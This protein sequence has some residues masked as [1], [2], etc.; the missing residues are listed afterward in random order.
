MTSK[1]ARWCDGLM[2]AGWLAA[3]IAIPLFFNIHSDR[4]FEPDKLTLLRSI[5]VLM[6][7]AWL[8]KFIDLQGWQQWSSLHPR[9]EESIWRKPFVLPV[10]LLVI[11]YLI[12]NI[13]SVTPTVSWAGSYQ[14]LQGTYTTLSY[15]VIFGIMI[16]TMRTRAQV[17]RVVTAVI[18]TS[19]P[20]AFYGLL[21]HFELD[22]LPWGGNTAKRI[23]GHMG[24]AIFIAA[25]LI[26]AV[27]LTISRI[28]DAFTSILG[29]EELSY[30][31]VIRSSIYI[32]VVAIQLIAIYWSGSR[33]PWLGLA[34]AAFA[35]IL[36]VLVTL[37]NASEETGRFRLLEVGK[38]LLMVVVG[39]V[40]A[41][42][43]V[44]VIIT[45]VINSGRLQSLA[46][47]MT[48]FVSFGAAVG[49][50]VVAVF[51]MIAARRGWRWLWFSWLLLAVVVGGWLVAFNF[52]Q[53]LNEQMGDVPVVGD[54]ASALV[55]WQELP[56]IGRLGRILESDGGTGRV[57]VL[58]WAGTLELIGI[59]EP[60]QFPDGE[61]DRF[62]F[63]RPLFGYGP[64]SMY[65]AYNSFYQPQ[66]A[67]IEARNASP[68]RSHN[69]TFDA[70]VIT[71]AV[72]F[73]VWQ[74]LYLS[75]FYYGFRWLGVV[76]SKRDRNILVALWILGAVAATIGL[77]SVLG[78]EFLGVAI[79][80]GSILGLI[81]YLIYYALFAQTNTDENRDPFEI[82]RL[83]MIGLVTAVLAHYVEIH[84]GIAIA[85]TRTH[86][87]VYIGLMFLVGY[88]LPHLKTQEEEATSLRQKR[89]IAV[90]GELG[91]WQVILAHAFMLALIIGIL[92]FEYVTYS[93]PP[94]KQIT[95][96]ADL[97]AG[98]IF[99]QSFFINPRQD[100]A[101]RPFLF[102]M[103]ILTWGLG[104]FISLSEMVKNNE[105]QFSL[106]SAKLA[107][108]RRQLVSGILATF[109]V[110][111]VGLRFLL[112]LPAEP[113]SNW[114][115][116]RSLL[117]AWA[118]LCLIAAVLLFQQRE[119]GRTFAGI[120]AVIGLTFA[121]PVLVAGNIWFSLILAAVCGTLLYLLWE[122]SWGDSLGAILAFAVA[123]LSIGLFMGYMQATALRSS[124]LFSPPNLEAGPA[125]EV[126]R[127]NESAGF[128]TLFYLFVISIIF[129]TAFTLVRTAGRSTRREAFGTTPALIGLVVLLGLSFFAISRTNM[130]IIQADIIYKRAKPF[131]QA[132]SRANQPPETRLSNW[133][134][135]I[136]IYEDALEK[137]P[138]EDFYYL[139]IGRAYLELASIT[140][141]P[142]VQVQTLQKADTALK[143]AQ[144]INPLNTDHTANLARLNTRWIQLVPSERDLRYDNALTYYDEALGLS[145]QNSVIRNE[146]AGL[147]LQVGQAC[148]QAIDILQESLDVDPY[149]EA[150]YVQLASTL[151]NC[152]SEVT[153]SEQQNYLNLSADS[154]QEAVTIDDRNPRVW[155]RLGQ[156]RFSLQQYELAIEAYEEAKARNSGRNRIDPW[157]IDYSIALSYQ[158]LDDRD[159][160]IE[161]AQQALTNAPA[162]QAGQIQFLIDQLSGNLQ[163][164]DESQLFTDE[165][166][167]AAIPPLERNNFYTEYPPF[168]IETGQRYDAIITTNK[169]EMRFRLFTGQTPLT[170][171]NFAYL[172]SQGFYDGTIFHRVIADFMAQAGDP[173][174][175]GTGGPGYQ[176]QDEISE[177]TFDSRGFL[178]MANAGPNTNGSQF[179]I[180]FVPT[181]HLNG[182]HTIFGRLIE[183]DDVLSSLQLR[184]PS[185]PSAPAD[186]IERI[187][188]IKVEE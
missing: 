174:G 170:V 39:G 186:V 10:F 165:R 126:A 141:D 137:A 132:G 80:F 100:F 122:K 64:E 7:A 22:P 99:Y 42:Y 156:T 184:D 164:G 159:M 14:R 152:A 181:P 41:Y 74:A 5:A 51:V 47:P 9:N 130:R 148:P 55:E 17:S 31:D 163:E 58:I 76:R 101:E 34:A 94:G 166:P 29:D 23:A 92:G 105:I 12:S 95:T 147:V 13:F 120:T 52:A 140:P 21:Q 110:V 65:V 144:D 83:L 75:V 69:E 160:A 175:T 116:G 88:L 67:T 151:T 103:I 135:A 127:A 185:D 153:E 45:A 35:F 131:D 180:T 115:L 179:F 188:I 43:L 24:N 53:P 133:N 4:V 16:H 177:R 63:L 57:R 172:A 171:N 28:I 62:N 183:G 40:A 119:S 158:G 72:G 71:G 167:L 176:F 150:T 187:D 77:T 79:P 49:L 97:T 26:M 134:T 106:I 25:Y 107:A 136:A 37:R 46:G 2:E 91:A 161:F 36:I 154:L 61:V 32:F 81:L 123:S 8:V 178:A 104:I 89:E 30:A 121:L 44:S 139:F 143:R 82:D 18:I 78:M 33:G 102:V 66:L 85:A 118:A 56:T 117:L 113:G 11:T 93:L 70:L 112:P 48:S 59:H 168:V 73:I 84:F 50:L 60:I 146:K 114:L 149:Y 162:G 96:A 86:F 173:S 138:L 129:I 38:A 145:P 20:V 157:Q 142:T 90:I 108:D 15:I 109:A 6:S 169:G 111:A 87:F 54:I 3:V 125:L 128:L 155:F 98:E 124:I 27:P 182:Q 1:L 19:I 68:D